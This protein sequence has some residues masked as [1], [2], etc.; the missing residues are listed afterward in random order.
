MPTN[1]LRNL[2]FVAF[3][4]VPLIAAAKA[5][6]AQGADKTSGQVW[7]HAG[8]LI[9]EPK[10][11]P[12]FTHFDYVNP[13]AP[14]GGTVRLSEEGGF[15]TF[16]PILPE[17]EA[18]TG[19][20]LVYEPL[21][22]PSLDEVSTDYGLLAEA[23]SYPDDYSSVTYRLKANAHWQDGEPVTPEDVV[24][25]FN[26]LI[27]LNP[28][29]AQYYHNVTKVEATGERDVTFHF[30]STG[31]R[32]LPKIVG[33][34]LVLPKHWWEGKDADGKQRD[35][36][37]S[38][39]EPPM[40]SG[41]YKIGSFTP[42]RTVSYE[43]DPNY[44]GKDEP[45]NVGTNNFDT[46]RYEY[47]RDNTVEFEAFKGDQ[48]DWWLENVARRWATGYDFPAAEQG[49]VVKERFE[50]PYR[51][52]G[53]MVGFIPNLRR[54]KFQDERV[55]EALNYAFDFETLQRDLFYGEYDRIDSYF[56]RTELASSGLPQGQ[57]LDILNSVKDEVPPSVFTTQYSNPVG[58]DPQKLRA[59]LREALKLLNDAG[60][61]LQGGK[62][63]GKD[64]QQLSFE[65]LL[66]GP[67]IEP[68]ALAFQQN[69]KLIGIEASVRTVD[70]PQYI[71]RVR[72][73]DFDMIYNGWV[74][75]LSPGNEQRF[76]WGSEAANAENSSNYAG[77]SDPGIDALI[78]K[79]I[80]A[81]NRTTLVAATHALDRVLLAHHYVIP[82]YAPIDARIAHWDRFGRPENLPEYSIGFPDIWWYDPQKA[83]AIK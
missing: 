46:I 43:R 42:G 1:I 34:V 13:D 67:T 28:N 66:N 50:N 74:Q 82:T 75:S 36:A 48:F 33:Q 31:N 68:V 44:W 27:E 29:R 53:L 79:I 63:V 16:N 73:R 45:V 61:T 70:S 55:R 38:T 65:I 8:A 21:M 12:D 62:L 78:D 7:H 37:H 47:F 52:S 76:F 58:G 69:L 23:F 9:G 25:S 10:Y 71:N 81:D 64:G 22:T 56:F 3:L 40:G 5:E 17:G 49:K 51:S 11:G 39:L 54:E 6:E 32:E 83:D 60:Y 30:D 77:I 20:G 24:W 19:L 57:E 15:D 14:K 4:L 59:N 35:I 18:A 80:F 2:A 72:S 26:K 41:P